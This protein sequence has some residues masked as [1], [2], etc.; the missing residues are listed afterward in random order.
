M[1]ENKKSHN[2]KKYYRNTKCYGDIYHARR[3]EHEIRHI[4]E[5]LCREI[6]MIIGKDIILGVQQIRSAAQAWYLLANMS[7][8]RALF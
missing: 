4:E 7:S 8:E 2:D 1:I 5:E 6:H 3:I